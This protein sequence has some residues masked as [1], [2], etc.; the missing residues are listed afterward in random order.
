MRWFLASA[1]AI[2]IGG[3]ALL[4]RATPHTPHPRVSTID[5]RAF[6]ASV[7]AP[8]AQTPAPPPQDTPRHTTPSAPPRTPP[9][10]HTPP[11][12][13][14]TADDTAS[15]D[16]IAPEPVYDRRTLE[17]LFFDEVNRQRILHN[18]PPLTL[19][20]DLARTA[21]KY[22]KE[23]A[24]GAR[25]EPGYDPRTAVVELRHFGSSFGMTVIERLRHKK[26]Y[27]TAR[28][29]EN[30]L[31]LPMDIS[32]YDGDR[33]RTRRWRTPQDLATDGARRWMLSPKHR[34]N[35]L[36]AA[37]THAGVGVYRLDNI[38]VVVEVF[39]TKA[40]CGYYRGPCCTTTPQCFAGYECRPQKDGAEECHTAGT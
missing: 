1:L 24:F 31:S 35:I 37:Y 5:P 14:H 7:T 29:G 26:V 39:I 3:G 16:A 13:A 21:R 4:W 30:I 8:P 38:L 32:T 22:A 12:R 28:A 10:Q 18:L 23:L 17:K 33:L 9:P 19:R 40:D 34:A 6:D 27:D 11:P 25:N 2:I 36:T 20:K 15:P